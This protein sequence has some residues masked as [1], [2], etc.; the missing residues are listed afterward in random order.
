M[1]TEE[2][3]CL[4][5]RMYNEASLEGLSEITSYDY[6]LSCRK[7]WNEI[8][9][10]PEHINDANLKAY[11][12]SFLKSN[13]SRNTLSMRR[14]SLKFLYEKVLHLERPILNSLR[15][16]RER[17]LP[18]YMSMSEVESLISAMPLY[19]HRT[20]A[21]LAF[22]CGLRVSEVINVQ[23]FDIC[24]FKMLLFI[25]HGKGKKDRYVPL[26]LA[27]YQMLRQ[28]WSKKRPAKPYI[29]VNPQTNKPY[30]RESSERAFTQARI[31]QKLNKNYSYHTLRHSYATCLLDAGINIRVLQVY[32]G[33]SNLN[34]TMMYAHLSSK[35]TLLAQQ[36]VDQLFA[37]FTY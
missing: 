23:I 20:M 13:P 22:S 25:P 8:G 21:K 31:S 6:F 30:T 12:I 18:H 26:P 37:N 3:Q 15:G 16:G 14:S 10:S 28:Y 24:K 34:T 29:F 9:S 19:H 32:L 11:F 1:N 33:H 5:E 36:K 7:V 17:K 4:R 2:E 27:A 35:A